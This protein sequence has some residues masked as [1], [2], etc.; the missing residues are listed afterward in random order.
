MG[1]LDLAG[2]EVH[3]LNPIFPELRLGLDFSYYDNSG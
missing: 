3:P 1:S 2:L